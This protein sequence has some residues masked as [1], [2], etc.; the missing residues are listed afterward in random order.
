MGPGANAH[1]WGHSALISTK[2]K[3]KSTLKEQISYGN[4]KWAEMISPVQITWMMLS[5]LEDPQVEN[6]K[7]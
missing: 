2:S 3:R 4:L 7:N 6:K 5:K 1:S